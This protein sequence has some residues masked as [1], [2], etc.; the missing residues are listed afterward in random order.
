[1]IVI[2]T[3][4][5]KHSIQPLTIDLF[6]H[7]N[8]S[9]LPTCPTAVNLNRFFRN[10]G[11]PRTIA[12]N[13]KLKNSGIQFELVLGSEGVPRGLPGGCLG[14]AWGFGGPGPS[15]PPRKALATPSQPPRN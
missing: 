14:V 3:S 11:N 13:F 9:F 4:Y 6:S 7:Q 15:E 8:Y 10:E 1:M 5:L 12:P 2:N